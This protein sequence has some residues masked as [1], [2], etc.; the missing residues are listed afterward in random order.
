MG[1][2]GRRKTCRGLDPPE[3]GRA[4]WRD[5]GAE[6]ATV[7]QDCVR[8]KAFKE[9]TGPWRW[10]AGQ[11]AGAIRRNT[12]VGWLESHPRVPGKLGTG[13]RLSGVALFPLL[14]PEGTHLLC[15]LQARLP[16]KWMAPESIFDKVYTTQ[17]DVWS[18]GVLLWEIFSLGECRE[19]EERQRWGH[20]LQVA[21]PAPVV[22]WSKQP[23]SL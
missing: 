21:P 7:T 22:P 19:G 9:V 8:E 10:G 20:R 14:P 13:G 6:R 11:S 18:F 3:A 5:A 1:E 16:L 23:R 12:Q 15:L 17:S 4:L 2:V